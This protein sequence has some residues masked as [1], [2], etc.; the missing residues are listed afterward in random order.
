LI[1]VDVNVVAYLCLGGDLATL[2]EDALLRDSEW[3]AP[4]LWRSEFR[5]VVA[6]FRRRGHLSKEASVRIVAEAEGLFFDREHLVGSDA[7]LRLVEASPCSAYDCEYVALA[8]S[9]DVPLV[10]HDRRVLESFPDTAWSMQ[11]FLGDIVVD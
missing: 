8:E 6:G 7:V 11:R 10:T 5:N 1:V 4:L 9:F 3:H 2:A